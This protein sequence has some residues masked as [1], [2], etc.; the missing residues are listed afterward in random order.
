MTL[1]PAACPLTGVM[2]VQIRSVL[3]EIGTDFVVEWEW[4]PTWRPRDISEDGREQLRAIVSGNLAV[5]EWLVT[6][7]I[8][9]KDAYSKIVDAWPAVRARRATS[10]APRRVCWRRALGES[11]SSAG[12]ACGTGDADL[13]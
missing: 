6:G 1:T 8:V 5:S 12:R 10:R 3:A 7:T 2:E 9:R 4:L 13:G 11:R